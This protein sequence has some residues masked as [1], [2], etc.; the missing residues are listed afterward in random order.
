MYTWNV[1]RPNRP[2]LSLCACSRT[3]HGHRV[4][5]HYFSVRQLFPTTG[6]PLAQFETRHRAIWF[7]IMNEL[8]AFLRTSSRNIPLSI[9]L[10]SYRGVFA[11]CRIFIRFTQYPATPSDEDGGD[12]CRGR[13]KVI[14]GEDRRG[15]DSVTFHPDNTLVKRRSV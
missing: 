11:G 9:G 7:L 13:E 14:A 10:R 6:F 4:P 5:A 8:L 3:P 12:G 15:S 1:F 2:R